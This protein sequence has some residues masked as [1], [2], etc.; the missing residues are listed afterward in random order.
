LDGLTAREREIL[1]DPVDWHRASSVWR[2]VVA[3]GEVSLFEVIWICRYQGVPCRL[4]QRMGDQV[5][6]LILDDEPDRALRL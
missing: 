3:L 2:R 5:R 1:A 6:L 4:L